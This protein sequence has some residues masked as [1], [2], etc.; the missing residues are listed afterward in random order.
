MQFELIIFD[1]EKDN[2]EGMYNLEAAVQLLTSEEY[3]DYRWDERSARVA[4]GDGWSEDEEVPC[5]WD[6]NIR[7]VP[8]REPEPES[9][10]PEEKEDE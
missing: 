9:S 3:K 6:S 8:I 10:Q 2:A 7:M 1:G 5:D 4:L